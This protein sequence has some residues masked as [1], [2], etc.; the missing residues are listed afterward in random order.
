MFKGM[1][2]QFAGLLLALITTA[3]APIPFVL[4]KY[5]ARIRE[6]SQFAT[7]DDE[8][9]APKAAL[10]DRTTTEKKNVRGPA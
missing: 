4:F 1:G 5:G 2:F 3:L 10:D 9:A 8:S 7:A 6:K